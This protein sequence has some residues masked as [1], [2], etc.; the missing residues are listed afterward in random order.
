VPEV[1]RAQLALDR[2]LGRVDV[3]LERL[4]PLAH[5]A[6]AELRGALPETQVEP[7]AIGV[8]TDP[9]GLVVAAATG[10]LDRRRGADGR[11]LAPAGGGG[12][13][14]GSLGARHGGTPSSMTGSSTEHR[15]R[16]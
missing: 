1:L 3:V 2:V 10:G 4:K 14:G 8:G 6:S 13:C 16:A 7:G 9:R 11:L 15:T 12:R 5:G